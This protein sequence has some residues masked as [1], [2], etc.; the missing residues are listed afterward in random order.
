LH[1]SAERPLDPWSPL[2]LCAA[3]ECLEGRSYDVDGYLLLRLEAFEEQP[4][5]NAFSTR[6]KCAGGIG[7]DFGEMFIP[8]RY[9]L[10]KRGEQHFNVAV[11]QTASSFFDTQLAVRDYLCAHPTAAAEYAAQKRKAVSDGARMFSTY[12]QRKQATSKG[13]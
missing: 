4:S 7:R 9:Y 6:T 5:I 13:L 1:A 3:R 2:A 10:R 8:G 12:S 11:A